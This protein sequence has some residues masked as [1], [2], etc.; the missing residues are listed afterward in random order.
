M[1]DWTPDQ[2]TKIISAYYRAR[3]ALVSTGRLC[4]ELNYQVVIELAGGVI[5]E[6]ESLRREHPGVDRDT[7]LIDLIAMIEAGDR[8]D[9]GGMIRQMCHDLYD[10]YG[11][12]A[13]SLATLYCLRGYARSSLYEERGDKNLQTL[14]LLDIEKALSYPVSIYEKMGNE[15]IRPLMRHVQ[16]KLQRVR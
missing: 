4:K 7:A 10:E 9:P 13:G 15:D 6:V 1:A 2:Q 5:D 8:A 14:A 16:I 12:F 11:I 3:S